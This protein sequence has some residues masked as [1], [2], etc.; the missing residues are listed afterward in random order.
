MSAPESLSS[1]GISLTGKHA[2]VTGGGGDIGRASAL[3]LA[4]AGA[5]VHLIGRNADR[6]DSAA[7]DIASVVGRRPETYPLDVTDIDTVTE[8]F[9]GATVDVLVNSAGTNIPQNLDEVRADDFDT[10]FDVNVRAAY[11]VTQQAVRAMRRDGRRGS[12]IM[13]SSQMGHV[14]GPKRSV[15][16]GSKWAVEGMTRALALE[17]GPEGI[18]VNTVA[19]TFVETEMTREFFEDAAFREFVLGSIPL[20]MMAQSADVAAAVEFLAG[21]ASRMITGTSIRVDGGWTAQ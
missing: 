10:V 8:L 20:G 12:I 21:D 7:A 2:W 17:L 6:L 16:C 9:Q 13:I 19:P 5:H 4:R 14:G 1:T 11:F 18:R 15:Y 3:A